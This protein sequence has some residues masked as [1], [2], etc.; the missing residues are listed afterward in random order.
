MFRIRILENSQIALLSTTAKY[1]VK[2]DP[3]N[4]EPKAE[5]PLIE[6]IICAAPDALVPHHQWIHFSVGCRK[7]KGMDYAEI[8]IFV[9]GVRVGAMRMTYP[10]PLPLPPTQSAAA[11]LAKPGTP[12]EAIRL[13]VGRDW[14]DGIEK[15]IKSIGKEEENEWMLGR[16]LLVEEAVTEDVV[17]LMHHLVSRTSFG[18]RTS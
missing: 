5:D 9:N 17:L 2:P 7:P 6:E 3:T 16:V 10:I 11:I 8:R 4:K 14:Q 13:S 12:A 15:E 1:P 18:I